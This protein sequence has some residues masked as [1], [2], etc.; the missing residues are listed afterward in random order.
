MPK[1]ETGAMAQTGKEVVIPLYQEQ[2][3]VGKRE[4]DAGTVHLKKTVVTETINQP[5]EL[6]RET[7]TIQREPGGGATSTAPGTAP[8]AAQQAQPGT[9][10]GMAQPGQAF[11]E[12]EFTIQLKSE[13]PMIQTQV[14]ESGRFV[15]QKQERTETTNIQSQI[16]REEISVDRGTAQVS[17]SEAVGGATS[18]GGEAR[19]AA[20]SG[21]AA[22]AITDLKTLT[23]ATDPQSVTGRSVQLSNAKVQEIINPHLVAVGTEG[24]QQRIHVYLQQPIENLK[25]GDEINLTGT[26]KA[27]SAATSAAAAMGSDISEKLSSQPFYVDAQS[28]RLGE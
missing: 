26:V 8:G 17:G 11:Q 2:V 23:S 24:E 12:Q 13:V 9:A 15:A 7:L 16:R 18:P 25:V 28:A 1:Q 14:V 6:R 20:A 3:N 5:V 19:G 4:V 22:G 21:A 10:P 27:P